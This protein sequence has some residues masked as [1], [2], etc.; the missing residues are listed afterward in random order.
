MKVSNS[1]N[2]SEILPIINNLIMEHRKFQEFLDL[3]ASGNDDVNNVQPLIDVRKFNVDCI[4]RYSDLIAG[5]ALSILPFSLIKDFS[6][7]SFDQNELMWK[8]NG[9]LSTLIP[10]YNSVL[11]SKKLNSM[12]RMIIATNR[13]RILNLKDNLLHPIYQAEFAFEG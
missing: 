7:A 9:H 4:A 5:S 10:V 1:F 12:T 13:D 2:R 8:I 11:K 6:F 3:A